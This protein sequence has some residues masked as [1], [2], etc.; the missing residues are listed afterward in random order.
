MF[1]KILLGE[2]Y[3]SNADLKEEFPD[4][5]YSRF[6]Q[7]V[8]IKGTYKTAKTGVE[9]IR[10]LINNIDVN[11][12]LVELDFLLYTSQTDDIKIP[13]DFPVALD[14]TKLSKNIEYINISSG[15][16]GFV[17][18]MNLVCISGLERA[19]I[20]CVER[21]STM[22]GVRDRMNKSI[23]SDAA[24]FIDVST[25]NLEKIASYSIFVPSEG[26]AISCD[27]RK[28]KSALSEYSKGSWRSDS[29]FW[30]NGPSVY[31]FV[32][33]TVKSHLLEILTKH[34]VDIVL[35]HQANNMMLKD[36]EKAIHQQNPEILVPLNVA[37]GNS[38]SV[39]IPKLISDCKIDVQ[40]K[41]VLYCGFGV[42]LKV[43]TL[44][45]KHK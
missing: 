33:S 38:V 22:I 2:N 41:T 7:R 14:G 32:V 26:M 5:N 23:F 31:K 17:D 18:L 12:R 15:C 28:T 44:I 8:G 24:C 1:I 6:E 29:D 3:I 36:I 45:L 43:S 4:W 30:M 34:N 35:L 37:E 9:F 19:G 16:S 39:S 25:K 13:G 20:I 40:G 11:K 27:P 21:Y 10:E 42:G